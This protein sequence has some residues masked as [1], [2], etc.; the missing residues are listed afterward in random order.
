MADLAS[1]KEESIWIDTTPKT[2]YP[3]LEQNLEVDVAVLGGGIAG[4]ATAF[5]LKKE[6][7]KVALVEKDRIVEA[8]TGNTTAKVTSQHALIYS[9][10]LK[11]LGK[12]KAQLY[13]D[14]N[15]SA[16]EKIK[17]IVKENGIDCDLKDQS[18]FVFADKEKDL[19]TIKKETEV[20]TSLNLPA[21]FSANVPL[22]FK[23]YGAVEFT[24]QAQFH[25]RKYLLKLASLINNGGSQV[26]EQS[27]AVDFEDGQKV[28]VK[29]KNGSTIIAKYLV[30]ATHFPIK[31]DNKPYKDMV[32]YRDY[33]I[34]I[35]INDQSPQGMFISA[36]SNFH[37]IRYQP[38]NQGDV[39]IIDGETEE[40][41]GQELD[42]EKYKSLEE[43]ARQNFDVSSIDYHWYAYDYGPNDRVPYIGKFSQGSDNIFVATGFGGWGM[44]NSHVA[45][46]IITDLITKKDNPWV[47]VFSPQ[48]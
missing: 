26:L 19:E 28:K 8:V 13:A 25:P 27:E 23:T 44:T 16:V 7:F 2:D 5:F 40:Y 1:V 21:K 22:P 20:A 11:N 35:K 39:I 24:N 34:G 3:S 41:K 38:T 12:E 10:L 15:Q 30:I 36:G 29:T 31:G 6:G 37:S 47:S 42:K 17:E 14:A 48:R 32:A 33:V 43:Y 9:D 45:A 46:Q 18:A 4:I